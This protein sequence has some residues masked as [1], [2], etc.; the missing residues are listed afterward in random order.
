MTFILRDVLPELASELK[1]LFRESESPH[2]AQQVDD[3]QILDRCRCGDSFC[4][5]I[6]TLPKPK[7]AWGKGHYTI[8]LDAETGM[9]IVDVLDDKIAE[10]EILYRDEIREKVLKLLP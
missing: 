1:N 4:A 6:Y 5:T 8:L 9:I 3:L 2:L 10:V 7:E